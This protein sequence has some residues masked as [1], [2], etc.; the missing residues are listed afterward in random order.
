MTGVRAILLAA[1]R[2]VRF[3]PVTERIPKPLFPWLNV[4]LARS[5]LAR[6]RRSG[7]E[8][9]AVNLHHLGHKIEEHLVDCASELPQLRFFP[10]T[11]ILGTA[12]A[13][14]NAARFLS[15]SD[16]LVVNSDA[17]IEPEYEAL[18]RRHRESGRQV[19]LLVVENREPD[20]YTPLQ[21]EG[22]RVTGFGRKGVGTVDG[23]PLLYT[24][25]CVL[26]PGLLPRIPPGET[27]L[28]A[29]L[30]EPL[31]ERREEIGWVRHEGPFAD[32]GRPGDF[33]GASLEALARGGP[34][35]PDS[36]TFD[37]STRVLTLRPLEGVEAARSVIGH[38]ALGAG[39]RLT[40]SVVWDGTSVGAGA[41]LDGCLLAGGVVLPGVAH[42]NVLLWAAPGEPA[43]GLPLA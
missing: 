42:E 39:A 20:R 8:E 4:A 29:G 19:T 30:W 10:E 41:R 34:F 18:V 22:D 21:S 32:L 33:L 40:R 5:H 6:L 1:G 25:V 7:V 9:A 3:R 26:S 15:E 23:T 14:R 37:E 12:G 2:G 16:F 36:G 11:E 24:G 28:V 35:P 43:V 13:L 27:S 38:A 31:L 17:A